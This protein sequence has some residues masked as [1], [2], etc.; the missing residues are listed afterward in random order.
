MDEGPQ[1]TG[2]RDHVP[3]ARTADGDGDVPP[4][5]PALIA[6]QAPAAAARRRVGL[7]AAAAV[8]LVVAVVGIV[9][10]TTSGSR[11]GPGSTR[12]AGGAPNAA[13]LDAIDSTLGA[14]TADLRLTVAID[15]PG[16]GQITASGDG[17]VDFSTDASQVTVAYQGLPSL[18]TLQMTEVYAGGSAYLSI[19]QISAALPGRSWISV[20]VGATSVAPGSSDPAAMFQILRSQGDQVT[21]LGASDVDGVPV[22]GYHV[23]ITEAGLQRRLAASDLPAGVAQATESEVGPGG[24]TLDV[25]VDSSTGLLTRMVIGLHLTLDGRSVTGTVTEDTS[26]YGVPVSITAPPADQVASLQQ[27]EQ[28][29]AG[30]VGNPSP[31]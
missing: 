24:V 21:P 16:E 5:T 10:G 29:A 19:P 11:T 6:P 7:V 12:A 8:V 20:P 30:A 26:D 2:A 9:A 23:V 3:P 27:F 25:Y 14:K 22:D 18:G 15:V 4:V 17:Q 31:S 1:G 28:A 13:V